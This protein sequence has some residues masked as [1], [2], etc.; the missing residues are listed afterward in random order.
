MLKYLTNDDDDDDYNNNDNDDYN[1]CGCFF[2]SSLASC[3]GSYAQSKRTRSE[4]RQQSGWSSPPMI[5][6]VEILI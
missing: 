3:I 4:G 2:V 1:C 5:K 6:L